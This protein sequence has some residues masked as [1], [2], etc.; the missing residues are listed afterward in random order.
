MAGPD[1]AKHANP[2]PGQQR[3]IGQSAPDHGVGRRNDRLHQPQVFGAVWASRFYAAANTHQTDLEIIRLGKR[4]KLGR[5]GG[6]DQLIP[7]PQAAN[8]RNHAD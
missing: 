2:E 6:H 7:P 8:H 4:C 1:K 3:D 5:A